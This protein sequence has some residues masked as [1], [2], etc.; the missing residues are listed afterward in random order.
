[1]ANLYYIHTYDQKRL[2]YVA[3]L[4]R[5]FPKIILKERLDVVFSSVIV[6]SWLLP[7]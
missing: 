3:A 2:W 5:Y 7:L 4:T 6:G 1:M